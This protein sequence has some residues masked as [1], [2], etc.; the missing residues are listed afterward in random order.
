LHQ[1]ALLNTRAAHYLEKAL[2]AT[3]RFERVFDYP[4]FNEFLLK[5]KDG[6]ADSSRKLL[7]AGFVPPLDAGSLLGD[8]YRDTLL[9]AT[10]ELL[11]RSD[12]DRAA[13][14]LSR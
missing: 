2:V 12:L 13:E 4:F 3:G 7:D 5:A 8:N 6:A 1:L 9:F 11:N 10:T 14:A